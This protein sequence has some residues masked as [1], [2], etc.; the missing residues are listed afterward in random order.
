MLIIVCSMCVGVYSVSFI[1]SECSDTISYWTLLGMGLYTYSFFPG[2]TRAIYM[3]LGV[4]ERVLLRVNFHLLRIKVLGI[5][6]LHG[7]A[8]QKIEPIISPGIA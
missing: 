8:F 5:P 7:E 1:F 4:W 2:E 3:K 6:H